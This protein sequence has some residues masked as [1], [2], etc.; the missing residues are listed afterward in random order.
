MKKKSN[1]SP[2]FREDLLQLKANL[3]YGNGQVPFGAAQ[4]NK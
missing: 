2:L 4:P 3:Q 1:H